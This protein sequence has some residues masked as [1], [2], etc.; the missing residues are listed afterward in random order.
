[1][2]SFVLFLWSWAMPV[3]FHLDSWV[4][5]SNFCDKQGPQILYLKM[6][7]CTTWKM[8]KYPFVQCQ[9][10]HNGCCFNAGN[11]SNINRPAWQ[12]VL[13]G[14]SMWTILFAPDTW[15]RKY[16][17]CNVWPLI[18]GVYWRKVDLQMINC[19]NKWQ[20][21]YSSLYGIKPWKNKLKPWWHWPFNLPGVFQ[22]PLLQHLTI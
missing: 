22:H 4:I 9:K 1:M 7:R 6:Y 18:T 21:K 13:V 19:N 17:A 16:S 3:A 15:L 11:R 5:A 8:A 14:G 10:A 20:I 12:Q 2:V